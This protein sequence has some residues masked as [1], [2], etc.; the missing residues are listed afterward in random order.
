MKFC[1]ITL[2]IRQLYYALAK[3][4][5]S[6][7]AHIYIIKTLL[8]KKY[9]L[10]CLSIYW[11]LYLEFLTSVVCSESLRMFSKLHLVTQQC[12]VHLPAIRDYSMFSLKSIIMGEFLNCCCAY[13]QHHSKILLADDNIVDRILDTA[14]VCVP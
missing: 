9:L 2:F 5:Q 10:N 14:Q 1:H 8:L 6:T 13:S 3:G 7:L 11:V 12:R 4:T